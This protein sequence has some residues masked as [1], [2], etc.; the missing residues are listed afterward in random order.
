[1]SDEINHERRK[2]FGVA[3][4]TIAAVELGM[5]GAAMAQSGQASAARLPDIK[6][7]THTSFAALKQIRAG[8]LEVGYAE[9]GPAEGRLFCCCTAGPMTF[10]PM[11][12]LRPCLLKPATA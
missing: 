8:V 2:F 10:I 4:M 6:R 9:A 5:A 7:G 12:T 11:S 1:M 3:A